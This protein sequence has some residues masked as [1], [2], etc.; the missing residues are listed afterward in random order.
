MEFGMLPEMKA[1]GW[2][3]KL[4]LVRELME[5]KSYE[6]KSYDIR[7]GWYLGSQWK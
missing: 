7:L 3:L 4:D 1:K 5:Y 6:Y 2:N